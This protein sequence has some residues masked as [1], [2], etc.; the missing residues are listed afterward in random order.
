MSF[1]DLIQ[2]PLDLLRR[3]WN[4]WMTALTEARIRSSLRAEGGGLIGVAKGTPFVADALPASTDVIMPVLSIHADRFNNYVGYADADLSV[5]VDSGGQRRPLGSAMIT[6]SHEPLHLRRL[7]FRWKG[8]SFDQLRGPA[9]LRVFVAAKEL[10][11]I[12]FTVLS[13]EDLARSLVVEKLLVNTRLTDGRIVRSPGQ[14]GRN[15]I[16][17]IAPSFS[18]RCPAFAPN[19]EFQGRLVV[20]QGTRVLAGVPLKVIANGGELQF[21]FVEARLSGDLI[22]GEPLQAR[23]EIATLVKALHVM[24]VLDS[25]P[26]TNYEGTLTTAAEKAGKSNADLKSLLRKIEEIP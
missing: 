8:T 21:Q 25:A 13:W 10:Q 3:P 15:Q 6:L 1:T 24:R 17:S 20:H 9:I 23:V 14:I 4:K 18:V 11:A 16:V 19:W 26:V 12:P 5:V 22:I 2:G 7:A